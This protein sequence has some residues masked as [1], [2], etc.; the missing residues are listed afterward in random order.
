M[1]KSKNPYVDELR[2][3]H[4]MHFDYIVED[5]VRLA[6]NNYI[7]NK[8]SQYKPLRTGKYKKSPVQSGNAAAAC[9]LL[10]IIFES[11]LRRNYYSKINDANKAYDDEL[12]EAYK[13]LSPERPL[14]HGI[15]EIFD[16]LELVRDMVVH[17][18][19]FEG[20]LERNKDHRIVAIKEKAIGGRR[21][22]SLNRRLTPRLK[23]S[24]SPN[25]IGFKDI[26]IFYVA[27]NALLAVI[28]LSMPY[29]LWKWD[30]TGEELEP[31][32]W[33][34]RA[35]KYLGMNRSRVWLEMLEIVDNADYERFFRD[36]D[37]DLLNLNT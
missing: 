37:N 34:V 36:I 33:F 24:A 18:Y 1:A 17:A 16:E 13:K 25:Q 5:L 21:A 27:I 14:K 15:K 8:G 23:L 6:F 22:K 10:F 3:S 19:L 31:E 7:F 4:D 2:S 9:L 11:I 12:W 26:A 32:K 29:A 28:D 20:M 30:K 35:M